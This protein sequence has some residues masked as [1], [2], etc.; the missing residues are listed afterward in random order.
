[1]RKL[2][3]Q[4]I[5]NF[6][7][8]TPFKKSNTKVEITKSKT[9]LSL[10]NNRI[11]FKIDDKIAIRNAGYK[12]NTTKE[13]LNGLP[14]VNIEEKNDIWYLNGKQWNGKFIVVN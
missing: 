14:N 2:T 12:T 13:R 4:A 1:M 10:F 6:L 5:E 3:E 8:D 7:N 11:A 9:I